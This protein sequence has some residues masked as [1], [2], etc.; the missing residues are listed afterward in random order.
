MPRVMQSASL[1][2]INSLFSNAAS[3]VE[4][5]LSTLLNLFIVMLHFYLSGQQYMSA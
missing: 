3:G 5:F 1:E 2:K 4:T